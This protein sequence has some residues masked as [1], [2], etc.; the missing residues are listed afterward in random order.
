MRDRPKKDRRM[1]DTPTPTSATPPAFDEGAARADIW[2]ELNSGSYG[3]VTPRQ[4]MVASV[5]P[6]ALDQW[7]RTVEAKALKATTLPPNEQAEV[8]LALRLYHPGAARDAREAELV[9]AKLAERTAYQRTVRNL[10]RADNEVAGAMAELHI[11]RQQFQREQ[12][13][14]LA[15]LTEIVRHDTRRNPETGSVEAVPVMRFEGQTA[16]AKQARFNEL[17]RLIAMHDAGG[18]EYLRQLE[19][20]EQRELAKREALHRRRSVVADSDR[21]ADVINY[22]REVEKLAEAKARFRRDSF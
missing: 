17:Q 22:Q 15:E 3:H 21:R 8:E 13:R 6:V 19:A 16:A 9:K 2:N 18:S 14:L 20:A 10:S 7:N 1:S 12:D 11:Q 4:A 5:D